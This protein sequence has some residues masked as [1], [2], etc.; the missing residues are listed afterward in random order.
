MTDATGGT[1]SA[2][3]T[4]ATTGTTGAGTTGGGDETGSTGST[5]ASSGASTGGG[6]PLLCE[7][8]DELIDCFSSRDCMSD[9]PLTQCPKLDLKAPDLPATTCA[10]G[11]L[12]D[13][14][15]ASFEYVAAGV[16]FQFNEG[17]FLIRGPDAS[18]VDFQCNHVDIS[19]TLTVTELSISPPDY[20]QGCLDLAS[21][22]EQKD[23]MLAGLHNQGLVPT[24]GG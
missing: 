16:D 18:G 11:L 9:V 2:G 19:S 7:C 4:G 23:C 13:R 10:L 20:F 17:E 8:V 24:C 12:I 5:G 14:P 22:A 15:L 21:A 6:A 3:T 1:T